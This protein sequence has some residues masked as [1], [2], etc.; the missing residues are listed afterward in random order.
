MTHV[1]KEC[2]LLLSESFKSCVFK[3]P[4][5]SCLFKTLDKLCPVCF[6]ASVVLDVSS[7]FLSLSL[8]PKL[9]IPI[10]KNLSSCR[11]TVFVFIQL[12]VV[13]SCD[14][15]PVVCTSSLSPHTPVGEGLIQQ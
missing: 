14:I 11:V 10:D 7:S 2:V 15:L 3:G 8:S 13:F 12:L 6:P 1:L 4:S 9:G 5:K